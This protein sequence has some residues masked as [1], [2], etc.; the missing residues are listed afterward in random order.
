[1]DKEITPIILS[2]GGGITQIVF[3]CGLGFSTQK[4]S[5]PPFGTLICIREDDESP[6]IN[7]MSMLLLSSTVPS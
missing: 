2:K 1:M 4:I 6:C 3:T 7:I 5:N